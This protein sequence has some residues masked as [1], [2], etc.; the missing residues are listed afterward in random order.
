MDSS[1][2][3]GESRGAVEP[4]PRPRRW[5]RRGIALLLGL[6]LA[7][8]GLELSLRLAAV[9]MEAR[10]ERRDRGGPAGEG[11]PEIWCLGDSFTY[12]LGVEDRRDAY[13]GQLQALLDEGG[14]RR[15]RVVNLGHPG[16]NSSEV[17]DRLAERLREGT[18]RVALVLAGLNNFWNLASSSV[19]L[20]Q[21]PR[22][23]WVR[24]LRLYRLYRL[25]EGRLTGKTAWGPA[26]ESNPLGEAWRCIQYKDY[27]RSERIFRELLQE[28]PESVWA[29]IGL[30]VVLR[31]EGRCAEALEALERAAPRARE[32]PD[33][34]LNIGWCAKSVGDPDRARQAFFSATSSIHSR[35]AALEE[36]GWLELEQGALAAAQD[37]FETARASDPQSPVY[38]DG[39]GWTAF[40]GGQGELARRLFQ[41]VVAGAP[42]MTNSQLGLAALAM[43]E[44]DLDAAEAMLKRILD[45]GEKNPWAHAWWGWVLLARGDSGAA[46]EQFLAA[47]EL[48]PDFPPARN[49]LRQLE[50]PRPFR[51]RARRSAWFTLPTYDRDFIQNWLVGADAELIMRSLDHDLRRMERLARS[52]GV[53][54]FLQTYPSSI[55]RLEL[56]ARIRKTAE[57]LGLPLIDHRRATQKWLA[58]HPG[59]TIYCLDRHPNRVGY[60]IMAREIVTRLREE[61]VLE[62][63]EE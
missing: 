34:F 25:L 53:R 8:V 22:P 37:Y 52:A 2:P 24:R 36:L 33:L 26:E 58:E 42:E 18:P 20:G 45:R 47:L 21:R 60:G 17:A 44:D 29:L 13:P 4:A 31:K 11:T 46:R 61:G 38:L 41:Q 32:V 9:W 50:N 1:A 12:G 56:D 16:M 55:E 63:R 10:M 48:R 15:M 35:R 6:L 14:P 40:L 7:L 23:S 54:L 27:P 28:D 62:G 51:L 43:Q 30:G 19:F 39:L 59:E 5:L 57:E 49:A 3:E